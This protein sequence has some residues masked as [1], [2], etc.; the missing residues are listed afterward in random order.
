MTNAFRHRCLN[1]LYVCPRNAARSQ[2]AAAATEAPH[3]ITTMH[4]RP[5][6]PLPGARGD[7]VFFIQ[8]KTQNSPLAP[9]GGEGP[10]VR[11]LISCKTTHNNPL[12]CLLAASRETKHH[13]HAQGMCSR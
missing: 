12:P 10:G 8:Q 2:L 11:G 4:L 1:I 7:T 9:N 3:F 13:C 6:T 5:P